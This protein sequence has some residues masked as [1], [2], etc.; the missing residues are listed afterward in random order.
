MTAGPVIRAA[1]GGVTRRR[2]QTV[3]IFMV[4]LVSTAA[5]TL[6]LALLVDSSGPFQHAFAAQRGAHVVASIDSA[7]VSDAQLAATGRLP[8]VT[9][10]A[11]PFSE[12][13]ITLSLRPPP[14]PALPSLWRRSGWWAAHPRA[15]RWMISL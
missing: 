12:A 2:A 3:V 10:A 6:G 11:G 8:G 4:L 9:E 14:P 1:A 7:R 5:A 13:S 15:V